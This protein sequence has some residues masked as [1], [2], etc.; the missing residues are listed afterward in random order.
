[1]GGVTV[2]VDS[3]VEGGELQLQALRVIHTAAANNVKFQTKV[4]EKETA[5]VPWLL[6]VCCN[7]AL[8]LCFLPEID[9]SVQY[10]LQ[11][12]CV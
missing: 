11:E 6:Q 1:M 5:I 2:L 3:L 4:L 7:A 9:T 12:Y 10:P 8:E